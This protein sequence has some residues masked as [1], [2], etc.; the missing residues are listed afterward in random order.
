VARRPDRIYLV[1]D[2]KPPKPDV[3]ISEIRVKV[4]GRDRAMLLGLIKRL[5]K[6]WREA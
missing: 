1:E 6:R 5:R 3:W 4:R 2:R